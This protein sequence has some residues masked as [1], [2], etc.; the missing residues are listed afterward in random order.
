MV[1]LFSYSSTSSPLIYVLTSTMSSFHCHSRE[2]PPITKATLCTHS[3]SR[4]V[5]S[6]PTIGSLGSTRRLGSRWL[7]RE[8]SVGTISGPSHNYLRRIKE[9]HLFFILLVVFFLNL[10]HLS[11]SFLEVS[12][13][14]FSSST[15][16]KSFTP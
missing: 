8:S 7:V 3:C 5:R 16:S 10:H 12:D 2:G 4:I 9:L 15:L 13:E 14:L 6:L 11:H 1:C